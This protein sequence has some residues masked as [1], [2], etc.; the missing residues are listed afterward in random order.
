MKQDQNRNPDADR[1]RFIKDSL[2]TGV[3]IATATVLPG[4]LMA[5]GQDGSAGEPKAQKGY[6][7]TPHIIEYY[8]TMRS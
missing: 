3:G 1:R 8:K 5:A 4:T 2:V 6:H 7:L